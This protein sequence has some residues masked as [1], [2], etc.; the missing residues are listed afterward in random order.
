[1]HSWINLFTWRKYFSI[2]LL[3]N[4]KRASVQCLLKSI[5]FFFVLAG[6][7]FLACLS[8][9]L[10][11]MFYTLLE[12]EDIWIIRDSFNYFSSALPL[13]VCR[14]GQQKPLELAFIVLFVLVDV[15]IVEQNYF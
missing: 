1:M 3:R 11:W 4:A 12:I 2:L 9:L 15:M 13:I 8:I 10:I 6:L 14:K 7:V 5:N